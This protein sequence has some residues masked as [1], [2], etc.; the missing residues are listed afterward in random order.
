MTN[1]NETEYEINERAERAFDA[2]E[3]RARRERHDDDAIEGRA[4]NAH[5]APRFAAALAAFVAAATRK[6]A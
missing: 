6:A 5:V 4:E 2:E 3:R 1:F